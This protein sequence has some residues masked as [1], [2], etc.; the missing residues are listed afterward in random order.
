MP[1]DLL[2]KFKKCGALNKY[3]EPYCWR[4]KKPIEGL[5]E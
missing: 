1:L 5:K 2:W 4:C 3:S